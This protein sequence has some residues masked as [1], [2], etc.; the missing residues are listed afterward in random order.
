VDKLINFLFRFE[1]LRAAIFS[2]V[3]WHNSITRT[4]NDPESMKVASAFWCEED[5]WHGWGIKDD[6]NY[7]FHDLPEKSLGDILE[8]I[9]MKEIVY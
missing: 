2:E 4:L 6:G 8:I 9:V 3:D 5:G 1:S 7:Y